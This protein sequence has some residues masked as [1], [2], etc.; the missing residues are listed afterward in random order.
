MDMR[1][2]YPDMQRRTDLLKGVVSGLY[3]SIA[4]AGFTILYPYDFS[5]IAERIIPYDIPPL[6]SLLCAAFLS[7]FVL[8]LE[9]VSIETILFSA[10]CFAFACLNMD[11]FLLGIIKDPVLALAISRADHFVLAL[12]MLGANLHLIYR[13]CEKKDHWWVVWTGYGTGAI[14]AVFTPTNL[15][16]K[17]VYSYYWGFFARHGV[18]YDVMSTLWLSGLVYGIF[19]LIKA[20]RK[21][22]DRRKKDRVKYVAYG[23]ITACVLSMTNTPAIY[24][25]EI[26]PLGT[27]SFIPLLLLAYG[28]Y[29]YNIHIALQRLRNTLFYIG[30]FLWVLLVFSLPFI[31]LPVKAKWL[32]LYLG[33]G[34]VVL[35]YEPFRKLWAGTLNRC[36]RQS[37]A[38]IMADYQELMYRLAGTPHLKSMYSLLSSWFFSVFSTPRLA[39]LFANKHKNVF[40]GWLACNPESDPGLLSCK[41]ECFSGDRAVCIDGDHP[42]IR[43]IEHEKITLLFYDDI[44]DRIH[45]LHVKGD[46]PEWLAKADVIVAVFYRNALTCILAIG[47]SDNERSYLPAEKE[48]LANLPI[49][50][51]PYI[52]NAHLLETLEKKVDKR[53]AD[54]NRALKETR[55]KSRI[56]ERQNRILFSLFEISTRFYDTTSI[57]RLFKVALRHLKSL[58]PDFRFGIILEGRRSGILESGVFDGMPLEEQKRILSMRIKMNESNINDLMPQDR[59]IRAK[60]SWTL[61]PMRVKGRTIGKMVI[62]GPDIDEG[63]HRILSI[64]IAQISAMAHNTLLMQRLETMANTDSLTGIANRACFDREHKKAIDMCRRFEGIDFSIIIIDINEL[65]KINDRF[66]HG[67]GDEMIRTVCAM[68]RR[69][70]RNTDILSRIGGDE[71]AILMHA[72]ASRNARP[73]LDRIRKEE[74]SLELRVKSGD[75]DEKN[76]PIRISLGLAGSDETAPENVLKLADERMY[77][78]KYDYYKLK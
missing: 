7:F 27:F 20:A 61:I 18:L 55:E 38:R 54:L 31:F 74:K 23:F 26:Y 50:L 44:K 28:L 22:E 5:Y 12:V 2:K 34:A 1:F 67:A 52:E 51:P 72:T 48:I 47:D 35:A 65:K 9:R 16:L 3:I 46:T 49:V 59:N 11:C 19:L 24:G 71:F 42:F 60:T 57:D 15:Y 6:L 41:D 64:F 17:G 40:E 33:L 37:A 56:I 78:N 77:Q 53:T 66:G 69:V 62:K 25:H 30:I 8:S 4:G 21:F 10:I 32:N 39:M 68:L 43:K 73:L 29:R 45:G 58:F 70:C 13:V 75:G 76:F 36:F 14:M 63:T